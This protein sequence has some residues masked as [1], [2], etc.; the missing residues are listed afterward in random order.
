MSRAPEHETELLA[1][2]RDFWF[3][4]AQFYRE[5]LATGC[6]MAFPGMGLLDRAAAIAGIA[7]GPRW[8]SVD[9]EDV[10]VRRLGDGGAVVSYLA[11]ARRGDQAYAAVVGSAYLLDRDG[12]KLA[13]HQHGPAEAAS[14]D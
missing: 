1:L 11:H 12:W 7:A 9:M 3:G 5:H 4:D 6:R 10:E 14:A 8:D 13:Y 2:E